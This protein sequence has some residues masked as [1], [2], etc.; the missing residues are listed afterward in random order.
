LA[1]EKEDGQFYF[2]GL[3]STAD[4]MLKLKRVRFEENNI[5]P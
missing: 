2:K 5:L 3:P 4:N 1:E